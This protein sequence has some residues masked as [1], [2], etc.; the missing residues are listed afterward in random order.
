MTNIYKFDAGYEE[1]Q[2]PYIE[3]IVVTSVLTVDN[4]DR[5]RLSRLTDGLLVGAETLK[6][7]GP[8]QID[9]DYNAGQTQLKI[10]LVGSLSAVN[11]LSNQKDAAGERLFEDGHEVS[12][13]VQ[14]NPIHSH[15]ASSL[16]GHLLG[17]ARNHQQNDVP[18]HV[19]SEYDETGL[20][21]K[22]QFDGSIFAVSYLLLIVYLRFTQR[23]DRT[24]RD[25][26][27]QTA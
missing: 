8:L 2:R 26:A 19:G 3:D 24:A 6:N 15:F 23:L 25:V 17:A 13:A 9:T 4:V 20:Q 27:T 14:I 10:T 21:L 22:L 11:R 5:D 7:K 16:T 1:G 18:L 12:T